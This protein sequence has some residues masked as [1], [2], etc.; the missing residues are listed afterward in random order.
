MPFR[1]DLCQKNIKL[2]KKSLLINN[3]VIYKCSMWISNY[4]Y[5]NVFD[6]PSSSK[7]K[8]AMES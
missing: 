6:M 4:I 1:I 8:K 3:V 7:H 2:Q 5:E